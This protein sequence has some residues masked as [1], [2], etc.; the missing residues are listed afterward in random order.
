MDRCENCGVEFPGGKND[1][2][3]INEGYLFLE[4]YFEDGAKGMSIH[5]HKYFCSK[6]CVLE[7]FVRF[8]VLEEPERETV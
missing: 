4:K 3:A 1:S 7:Y 8:I 5:P 2:Y 6:G